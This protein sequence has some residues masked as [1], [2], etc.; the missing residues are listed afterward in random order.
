MQAKLNYRLKLSIRWKIYIQYLKTSDAEKRCACLQCRRIDRQL[1]FIGNKKPI[2]DVNK[3]QRNNSIVNCVVFY[4]SCNCIVSYYRKFEYYPQDVATQQTILADHWRTMDVMKNQVNL[5]PNLHPD[6]IVLAVNGRRQTSQADDNEQTV[7]C[8]IR[9][10]DRQMVS[11]DRQRMVNGVIKPFK[12]H[13]IVV[14]IFT[15]DYW[16]PFV[17]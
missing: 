4:N 11:N 3:L 9:L 5:W 10:K 6:S 14:G 12:Q 8:T 16:Q 1:E 17:T 2:V 7:P 15:S 13:S